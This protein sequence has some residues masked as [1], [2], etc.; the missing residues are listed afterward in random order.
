MERELFVIPTCLELILETTGKR[1]VFLCKGLTQ[2]QTGWRRDFTV[3]CLQRGIKMG[4]RQGIQW[5]GVRN[6][7]QW[8][9][10]LGNGQP[11]RMI[12]RR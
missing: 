4:A 3:A 7:M 12:V 10:G 11:T 6:S 9:R 1:P 5:V 8:S 2:K